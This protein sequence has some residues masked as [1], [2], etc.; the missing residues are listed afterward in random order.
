[1]G[2]ALGRAGLAEDQAVTLARWCLIRRYLDSAI[3]HGITAID[4][5]RSAL[6]GKPWLPP[7]WPGL[8]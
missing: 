1:V 2:G 7:P 3:A 8:S 6:E 4:A 5:T